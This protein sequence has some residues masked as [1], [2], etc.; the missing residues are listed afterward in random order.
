MRSK[1]KILEKKIPPHG[2]FF[3]YNPIGKGKNT[4]FEEYP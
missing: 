4:H 3:R 1:T 2:L